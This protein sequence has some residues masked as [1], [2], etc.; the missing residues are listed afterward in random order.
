MRA[1]GTCDVAPMDMPRLEVMETP[2]SD[3]LRTCD[4]A[5]GSDGDAAVLTITSQKKRQLLAGCNV[6]VGDVSVMSAGA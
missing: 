4:V 1:A 6:N 3:G 5:P 2:G